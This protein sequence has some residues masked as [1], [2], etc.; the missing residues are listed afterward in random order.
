MRSI[1][2][3]TEALTE[4]IGGHSI[5]RNFFIHVAPLFANADFVQDNATA[6]ISQ[7]ALNYRNSP[8]SEDLFGDGNL[9]AGDRIPDL[10]ICVASTGAPVALSGVKAAPSEP[11]AVFP[12]A[13]IEPPVAR[14]VPLDA[15]AHASIEPIVPTEAESDQLVLVPSTGPQELSAAPGGSGTQIPAGRIRRSRR[16]ENDLFSPQ[17]LALHASACKLRGF[18]CRPRQTFT[19]VFAL[20]ATPLGGTPLVA[21]H[22]HL[23]NCSASRRSGQTIH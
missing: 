6:N 23:R 4:V 18:H 8:L 20:A 1:V 13:Q 9:V 17:P 15:Q 14:A 3:R 10:A 16:I 12:A 22:R 21:N 11:P 7:I 19:V 2:H 5:L